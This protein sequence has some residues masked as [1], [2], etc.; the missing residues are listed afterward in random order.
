MSDEKEDKNEWLSNTVR[1]LQNIRKKLETSC[2]SMKQKLNE[3]V[4]KSDTYHRALQ[5]IH[6][7]TMT[8][9]EKWKVFGLQRTK[10]A[11]G[12]ND[13]AKI[14]K[15]TV[16][17]VNPKQCVA[18]VRSLSMYFAQTLNLYQQKKEQNVCVSH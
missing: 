4:A 13:A 8:A 5:M 17:N 2:E 15:Q 7:E 1:K 14:Q 6:S 18:D 16:A 10:A 9:L 11:V 3:T 12:N